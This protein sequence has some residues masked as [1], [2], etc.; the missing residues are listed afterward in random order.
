M[1][2]RGSVNSNAVG[3]NE[4]LNNFTSNCGLRLADISV[5]LMSGHAGGSTGLNRRG[6]QIDPGPRHPD[7]SILEIFR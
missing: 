5:Q 6:T 4:F 7:L 1:L 2:V 3:N